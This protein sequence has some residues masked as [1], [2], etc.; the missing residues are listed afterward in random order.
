MNRIINNARL[1]CLLGLLLLNGC[2]DNKKKTDTERIITVTTVTVKENITGNKREYIGTVEEEQA[3]SLSFPMQGSLQMIQ[4]REGQFV[5]K[6][7]LLAEM[8]PQRVKSA[9]DAALSTLK[10]AEDG[11]QRL[12]LLYDNGSL[13][14]VQYVE[15]QTKLEQARSMEA[16]ARKKYGRFE[17]YGAIRWHYRFQTGRTG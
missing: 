2:G 7:T 17:T 11:M 4:G 14:E 6:G 9:H 3:V 1:F 13:P 15:T 12:Q 10:Q 8:N 5:S 16:I